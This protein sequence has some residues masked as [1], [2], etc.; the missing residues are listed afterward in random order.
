MRKCLGRE[1]QERNDRTNEVLVRMRVFG[2]CLEDLDGSRR[3]GWMEERKSAV[4]WRHTSEG[5]EGGERGGGERVV[6]V[7]WMGCGSE[8]TGVVVV[9]E[10]EVEGMRY[11][12]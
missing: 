10:N 6:E 2:V 8:V 4:C 9:V 11:G 3:V 5:G 1:T 12:V 7:T